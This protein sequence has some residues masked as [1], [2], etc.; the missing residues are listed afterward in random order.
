MTI[1]AAPLRQVL[2]HWRTVDGEEREERWP[3]IERFRSWAAGEG[4]RC[5]WTAYLE[6]E[7]GEWVVT[8]QGRI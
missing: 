3:T 1:P 6:D 5:A 4:L 7:D 2:I 8:D